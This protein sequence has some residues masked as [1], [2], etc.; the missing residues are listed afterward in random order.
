[1]IYYN[2]NYF[3]LVTCQDSS[4][5]IGKARDAA[6]PRILRDSRPISRPSRRSAFRAIP[7]PAGRRHGLHRL[8]R[9]PDA[10]GGPLLRRLGVGLQQFRHRMLFQ[11]AIRSANP[12]IWAR[13]V[14]PLCA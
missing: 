1:M 8:L 5:V 7:F 14:L 11:S 2:T 12:A 10:G 3:Y 13:C 4:C 6:A 9:P